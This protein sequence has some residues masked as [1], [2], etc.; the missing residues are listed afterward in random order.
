MEKR[1]DPCC[2]HGPWCLTMKMCV[3]SSMC[4]FVIDACMV[5]VNLS[6]KKTD[7]TIWK[8]IYCKF[9]ILTKGI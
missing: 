1:F 2:F 6:V 3:L 4:W 9:D 7:I 8:I 5:F